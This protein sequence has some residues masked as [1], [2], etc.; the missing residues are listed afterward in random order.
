[1]QRA[2]HNA[3]FVAQPSAWRLSEMVRKN[4]RW[5]R[6][7]A[8]DTCSDCSRGLMG[9][10]VAGHI[11]TGALHLPHQR[12]LRRARDRCANAGPEYLYTRIAAWLERLK[13]LLPEKVNVPESRFSIRTAA[14]YVDLAV[15]PYPSTM[16][17]SGGSRRACRH[18]KNVATQ[19]R[20]R[21]NLNERSHRRDHSPYP[22]TAPTR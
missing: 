5:A 14:P 9:V 4:P 10:G 3:S 17:A 7:A 8:V 1:M 12:T 20:A 18:H 21:E 13:P 16:K 2:Y 22:R 6:W 11:G 15:K 19:P